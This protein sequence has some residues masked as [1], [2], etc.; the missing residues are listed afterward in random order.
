MS[1]LID[2][3][4]GLYKVYRLDPLRR[5]PGVVFDILPMDIV[6]HIDAVDRVLHE[7]SAQSPGPVGDT[8]RPWYM[9][10]YQDDNLLVLHGSRFIEVYTPEHGRIENFTVTPH[11]VYKNGELLYEGGAILV[12]PRYVFHRI[13]SGKEGSASINLAVHYE[14]FDIET[15]FSIYDLNTETGEYKVIRKGSEDQR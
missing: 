11:A 4:P 6:P 2:E 5:T 3:I 12:W 1:M 13:V 8:A 14:G 7:S 10:T 9:H 15:N